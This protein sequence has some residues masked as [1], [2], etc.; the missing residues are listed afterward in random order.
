[1]FTHCRVAEL[2][3][4]ERGGAP[5]ASLEQHLALIAQAPD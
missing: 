4:L 2:S 1:M 3:R 5:H